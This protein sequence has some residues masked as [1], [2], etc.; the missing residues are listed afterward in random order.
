MKSPP[1]SVDTS[2]GRSELRPAPSSFGHPRGSRI[3]LPVIAALAVIGGSLL[4][5]NAGGTGSA[6]A[7]S[8]GQQSCSPIK[9]VIII[10]RENHSFD[11]LFGRFPHADGARTAKR[12]GMS[13]IKMA[14][15]LDPMQTDLIHGVDTA[16]R[17]IDGGKMDRFYRNP[18]AYQE[19]Q[20]V[21]DSQYYGYQVPIYWSYAKTF[22]LADHFFSTIMGDSFPN[23]LVTISGQAV[24]VISNPVRP[25]LAHLHS[26]GCDA[27][28][29]VT[30]K[31]YVG[32]KV[33][34]TFP[35]FNT[36]TLADEANAAGVSWKYYAAGYGTDGYIWSTFDSIKHIRNSAQWSTN[37]VT[38]PQF[39]SDV[40]AG[41]LP[42]I[43]WLTS[44]FWNSDHPPGS[45]CTG[46]NW[47]ASK[48]NEIMQSPLWSSTAIILVW[49]DFGGFY[50]H[51]AP[52]YESTYSL[53]PRVPALM[54]SPYSKP[55]FIYH[56][57]LDFRS[58]VT[59]VENQFNLP[60]IMKFKRSVNSIGAML[61]PNQQPLA[62]LVQNQI[63]NCPK[64]TGQDPYTSVLSNW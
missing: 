9:H 19:S 15:E 64:A 30:V 58:I 47:V 52:P 56:K 1:R 20:D 28:S 42:Q 21:A 51:L 45:I 31:Q 27:P 3:L 41:N 55:G 17:A 49:D 53:G 12:A 59:F 26:W 24:H 22:G 10:V 14:P 44:R 40:Q 18:F 13:T 37:V 38:T 4:T 43:S 32:G 33:A 8:C 35:C 39:D 62:P 23:H 25:N 46:Q 48:I 36:K 2:Q 63:P 29:D 61:D 6:A 34:T 60:H 57:R 5:R 11:N 16:R 54:I 7:A 50:D